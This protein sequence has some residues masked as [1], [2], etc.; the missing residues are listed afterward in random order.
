MEALQQQS[1]AMMRD[2]TAL[3]AELNSLRDELAAKDAE[4]QS[5]QAGQSEM[6]SNMQREF[7]SLSVQAAGECGRGVGEESAGGGGVQA[8]GKCGWGVQ[9]DGGMLAVGERAGE[10]EQ[11]GGGCRAGGG[12]LAGGE[13]LRVDYASP[14]SPT[15]GRRAT[16]FFFDKFRSVGCPMLGTA[17][18]WCSVPIACLGLASVTPSSPL[19][20]PCPVPRC[21]PVVRLPV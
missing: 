21:C 10:G 15:L 19:C 11:A 1:T 20:P 16:V 13:A 3:N 2:R 18:G 14:D 4:L 9:A 7:S 5:T 12:K 17:R 6:L 8:A